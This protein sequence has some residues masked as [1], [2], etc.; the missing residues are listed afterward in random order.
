MAV[1]KGEKEINLCLPPHDTKVAERGWK[2]ICQVSGV[3]KG[4][5]KQTDAFL[6]KIPKLWQEGE[7]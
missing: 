4:E 6:R 7:K 2:I 5:K 1:W 3:W